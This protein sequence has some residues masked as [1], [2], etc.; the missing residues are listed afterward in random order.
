MIIQCLECKQKTTI[1]DEKITDDTFLLNCPKCGAFLEVSVNVR[2]LKLLELEVPGAKTAVVDRTSATYDISKDPIYLKSKEGTAERFILDKVV[3]GEVKFPELNPIVY[4]ISRL[5][6]DENSASRDLA[7]LVTVDDRITRCIFKL[8]EVESH[9]E[10]AESVQDMRKAIERL[11]FKTVE[12]TA[13]AL[14]VRD[15]FLL[16]NPIVAEL[17]RSD[18]EHALTCAVAAGEIADI[19]H[20]PNVDLAFLAG[21]LKGAGD[22]VVAKVIS[23]MSPEEIKKF[24]I[25]KDRILE[26]FVNLNMVFGAKL[27]R[28]WGLPDQVIRTIARHFDSEE[29]DDKLVDI[30]SLAHSVCVKMGKSFHPNP[31]LSL[32]GLVPTHRLEVSEIILADL[33]LDL[34]EKTKKMDEILA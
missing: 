22:T 34:E 14:S 27:V 25:N 31:E 11:G 10:S 24:K 13:I 5:V 8:A 16:P 30:T 32:T 2:S 7:E 20:Y 1:G 18:W 4:Q 15:L 33:M 19:V 23:E 28:E 21:L 12:R 29:V 6:R 3:S 17:M 26:L 9:V